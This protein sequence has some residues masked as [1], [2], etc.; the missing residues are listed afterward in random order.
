MRREML[1][2]MAAAQ[3]FLIIGDD[4][5]LLPKTRKVDFVAVPRLSDDERMK[6]YGPSRDRECQGIITGDMSCKNSNSRKHPERLNCLEVL[7]RNPCSWNVAWANECPAKAELPEK[8]EKQL[9][10]LV[11]ADETGLNAHDSTAS[12]PGHAWI[13]VFPGH[14]KSQMPQ[15]L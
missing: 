3:E 15:E 13:T 6:L 10:E 11:V 12:A 8:P 9:W 2:T 5:P 7:M 4:S 14:L 1:K